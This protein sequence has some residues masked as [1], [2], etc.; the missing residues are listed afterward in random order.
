MLGAWVVCAPAVARAEYPITGPEGMGVTVGGGIAGFADGGARDFID[1]GGLWEARLVFA[2]RSTYSVEGAYVGSL[3]VIEALGLDPD[4]ELLGTSF[5]TAL[6]V[7][8]FGGR[9]RP[10]AF[11]GVGWTRYSLMSSP[12]T[13]DVEDR[14]DLLSVPLGGGAAIWFG[15]WM[16]DLRAT[17]R[18]TTNA[19]MFSVTGGD[20]TLDT[21]SATARLGFAL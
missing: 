20:V 14:D 2:P 21:W 12:P 1:S 10:Y 17:Y 16:I 3:H 18:A 9:V 8:P 13:A 11:L 19:D 6:R 4:A 7:S 15:Q 5:E